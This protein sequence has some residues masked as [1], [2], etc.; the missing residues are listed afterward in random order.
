MT[1][2]CQWS[3]AACM[4]L[5][6]KKLLPPVNS[7]SWFS[8]VVFLLLSIILTYQLIT[9]KKFKKQKQTQKKEC[10]VH[11]CWWCAAEQP[12]IPKAR[13][14]VN[15]TLGDTPNDGRSLVNL[16][17]LANSEKILTS[18]W[19][20]SIH[21]GQTRNVHVMLSDWLWAQFWPQL[22]FKPVLRLHAAPYPS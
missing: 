1:G 17:P 5:R 4:L 18:D 11:H 22:L 9:F 6:E 7:V 15:L 13:F 20:I 12:G 19:S 14:P 3:C 10:L 21:F 8:V 2:D 16:D